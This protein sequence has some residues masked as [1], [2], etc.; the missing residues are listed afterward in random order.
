MTA[1]SR[2]ADRRAQRQ[3]LRRAGRRRRRGGPGRG[4]VVVQRAAR[5]LH[6]ATA[7]VRRGWGRVV[8]GDRPLAAVLAG[9]IVLAIVMLSGPA[10][11]YLDGQARVDGLAAKVEALDAENARLQQRV[12]DLNDP[13]NIELLAR[14]QQGF[15]RPGEVPYTLVP[16]EVERPRITAP[17]NGPDPEPPAWYERAWQEVLRWFGGSG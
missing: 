2:L 7:G 17:R 4:P 16:P 9:A 14:E 12:E 6:A 11:R 13:L 3:A 8:S 1:T 15:I 10:Q 5:R